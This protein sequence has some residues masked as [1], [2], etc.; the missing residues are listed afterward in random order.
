MR[1]TAA[2]LDAPG[3]HLRVATIAALADSDTALSTHSP[4]R[5]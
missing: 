4:R 3:A 5:G 2:V 1:A